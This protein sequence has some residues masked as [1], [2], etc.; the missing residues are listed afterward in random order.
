[1]R[2]WHR[3]DGVRRGA[4]PRITVSG[5]IFAES[6]IML[7]RSTEALK[8]GGIFQFLFTDIYVYELLCVE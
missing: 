8:K 6:V 2:P 4:H 5:S 1:M 7:A 3:A